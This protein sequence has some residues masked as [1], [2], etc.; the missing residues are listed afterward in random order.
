M[1]RPLEA[2]V[3]AVAAVP[4]A[5]ATRAAGF[6]KRERR[7]ERSETG[8][9]SM[10]ALA[11]ARHAISREAI[12]SE[13]IVDWVEPDRGA[14]GSRAEMPSLGG[15]ADASRDADEL[16]AAA[17][18]WAMTQPA[19]PSRDGIFQRLAV[20]CA[21]VDPAGAAHLIACG[22]SPG[23]EQ[24]EAVVRVLE[25]WP[26]NE[27]TQSAQGVDRLPTES[28]RRCAEDK[29]RALLSAGQ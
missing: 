11:A 26:D 17:Q 5:L 25:Q 21:Q 28:L 23:A 14:S 29:R 4:Q 8:L 15:T 20:V 19:T 10:L 1:W 24:E 6:S 16:R 7:D 22:I 27:L 2:I 3:S 12:L 9:T 13:T 18:A